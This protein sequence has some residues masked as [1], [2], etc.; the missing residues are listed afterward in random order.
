MS[1]FTDISAALDARLSTMA[2]LPP[3]ASENEA[4]TP[5]QGTLFLRVTLLPGD[6]FQSSLGATGQDKTNGIYQVDIFAESGQGKAEA[7]AMADNVA[8][9]MKR[10]TILTYNSRQVTI[11]SAQRR[12]GTNSDGWYKIPVEIVFYSYTQARV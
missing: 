10:G 9:H 3:V 6:T 1:V 4:Y 8:N 2:N 12:T 7:I 5:T 11:R